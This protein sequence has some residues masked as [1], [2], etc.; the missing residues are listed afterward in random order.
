MKRPL[1][2]VVGFVLAIA[3][4]FVVG[5]AYG[6]Y[7]EPIA[8]VA[9]KDF[10]A[11][12]QVGG[13]TEGIVER[14]LKAGSMAAF[15]KWQPQGNDER[16]LNVIFVGMPPFSRHTCTITATNVVVRARYSHMD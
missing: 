3:A 15:T 1:K 16:T 5:L 6:Y 9:A 13:S 12:V 4:C 14:A 7:R 11:S 8:K 10:C 2:V